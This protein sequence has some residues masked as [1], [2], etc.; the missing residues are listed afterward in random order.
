MLPASFALEMVAFVTDLSQTRHTVRAMLSNKTTKEVIM[1]NE[2]T[3]ELLDLTAS[4]KGETAVR[5]RGRHLVLQL[6]LLRLPGGLQV[7]FAELTAELLDL[8]ATVAGR[9]SAGFAAVLACCCCS[10]SCS[11]ASRG[12]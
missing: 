3:R 11:T 10:S 9:G 12:D 4:V 1:F 2:L 6:H 5:F 8:R 7:I